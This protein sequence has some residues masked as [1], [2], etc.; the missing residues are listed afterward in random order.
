MHYFLSDFHLGIPN[1]EQSLLREKQIVAFLRYIQNDAKSVWLVGDLFDF[2]FEH[3][4]TAPK[5][6]TRLLGQLA[7]MQD[8]HIQVNI[9]TG[10]HDMWMFNYLKEEIGCTIFREPVKI[11]LDGRFFFIGHGDGLGP[12]DYGYK[13]IKRVFANPVCQW[14]FARLHP[15]FSFALANFW[16]QRSRFA[17][18]QKDEVFLGEDKEFLIQ[19]CKKHLKNE[20]IDYF[21]FGHR[22]LPLSINLSENS[23][24]INLG[25]WVTQF[26]YAKW[27]GSVLSLNKNTDIHRN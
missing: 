20:H 18:G 24:Y 26:T 7:H 23:R 12:G 11:E 22:H 16:S 19:F 9:F 15:N 25:D 14:L 13:V 1:R 5:G 8:S 3:T 6:F 17:N 21:I 2:W 4:Y 27:D 10:N